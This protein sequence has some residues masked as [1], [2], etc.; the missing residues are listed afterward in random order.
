[1]RISLLCLIV[2]TLVTPAL[3][4]QEDEADIVVTAT[5]RPES[6]ADVPATVT[7]IGEEILAYERAARSLPEALA[8]EPGVLLQK[9]SS[10]QTS[11]FIRGFTGFRTLLMVDGIRLNNSVFREGPNQYWGLVDPLTVGRLEIVYGPSSVLFGS[12][13]VGGTVNAIPRS[14]PTPA[15]NRR[16]GGRLY[17]RIGSAEESGT[18][19][20]EI[21]AVEPD[22][23][24]FM[25]GV[26]VRNF[27][28]FE[29]GGDVG[30]VK[31]SGYDESMA[32]MRLEMD[33]S[34]GLEL[35]IA[36]QRARQD[37]V[38]RT[39]STRYA[40]SWRGTS[41]GSDLRR[42]LDE[43]RDLVYARAILK[44]VD[45]FLDRIELTASWQSLKEAQHRVRSSGLRDISGFEV[46]T[47]GLAAQ[48]EA[49][50]S[51][52]VL[53]GG[54]EW[55][56]DDV[57]SHRRKISTDGTT[58][59]S[60]QGPVGDDA[61]YDLMGLY[62]QDEIEATD[63]LTVTAGLR[64]TYAAADADKVADPQTGDETSLDDSWTNIV[65]S[66]RAVARPHAD[67]R[68]HAGLGQ[69]FRAPN[70]SDLTRFDSARSG[71]VETP[72]P[73]LDAEKFLTLDVGV[74]AEQEGWSIQLSAYS[75][76][77]SDLVT[78]YPTGATIDGEAEVR[79]ANVGD[80]WVRGAEAR[81][82]IDVAAEWSVF[83]SI[84]W[85]DGEAD[86]YPTSS[87]EK[88]REPLSRLAPMQGILGLRYEHASS[89][90]W[91]EAQALM[92]DNQDDLSSRDEADTQRIPPG[93]TPGY[94]IFD[95]RGGVIIAD[96]VK[97]F[98][99]IEN[100]LDRE[101]RV[102]GSGQNA[103]GLNVV[104]GFNLTF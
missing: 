53:T 39:H 59:E 27:G 55:Y 87:R 91:A 47:I 67:W 20:V 92:A 42:D 56:H 64:F 31:E 89:R 103:P 66:L 16:V 61:T 36:W 70:L 58:S 32:D 65:G 77:M 2:F 93:G 101:Y 84:A 94:T 45:S 11:P 81:V 21:H 80:G 49:T 15:S 69:A 74:R 97:A 28:D 7:S 68:I 100:L 5:R 9:T 73:D 8:R 63:W 10:G 76:W 1:M 41:V 30:T 78:R 104:F 18:G 82:M 98:A 17:G 57:S 34:T 54:L 95:L 51:I 3:A 79:K 43:A 35:V 96:G 12:D 23:F 83:G 40:E 90:F 25:A 26:T 24:R 14:T 99:G 102:H 44:P 52:G 72:S 48:A 19:R 71:E 4:A 29:A 86:V 6:L 13:A 85:I 60:I 50:T 75:T 38:P 62:A 37:D 33:P 88:A 46:G 22:L